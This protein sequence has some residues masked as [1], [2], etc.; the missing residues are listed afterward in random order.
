M[1]YSEPDL[2]ETNQESADFLTCVRQVL[3][4]MR[5]AQPEPASPTLY[6]LCLV[7]RIACELDFLSGD[8]VF[9]QALEYLLAALITVG[10][11]HHRRVMGLPPVCRAETRQQALEALKRDTRSGSR[12]LLSWSLLYYSYVRVDLD[13]TSSQLA[14]A[15]NV[16]GRSVRRYRQLG[17]KRL[18]DWLLRAELRV[19]IGDPDANLTDLLPHHALDRIIDLDT[20]LET[21]PTDFDVA[22]IPSRLAG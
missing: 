20:L 19:R 14:Q 16:D 2:S 15:V 17:S 22:S 21:F 4:S 8:F 18:A 3:E 1:I 12:E 6:A 13:F 5:T 7:Q 9:Q 11:A 10:L